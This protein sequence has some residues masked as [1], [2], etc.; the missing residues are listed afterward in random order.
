KGDMQRTRQLRQFIEPCRWPNGDTAECN[1]FR[2]I[3]Q[4]SI[5]RQGVVAR[6]QILGQCGMNAAAEREIALP[7]AAG[8]NEVLPEFVGV[9]A[10]RQAQASLCHTRRVLVG[11][12]TVPVQV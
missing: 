2:A 5:Y 1:G 8:G 11:T 12:C 4:G 9:S 7:F 3:R 6:S 10:V